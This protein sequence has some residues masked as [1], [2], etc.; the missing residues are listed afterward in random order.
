M[1]YTH[2]TSHLYIRCVIINS[3]YIHNQIYLNGIY[4][5]CFFSKIDIR[6]FHQYYD[7]LIFLIFSNI[8]YLN[9]IFL[10]RCDIKTERELGVFV[11]CIKQNI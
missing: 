6:I 11:I 1:Q 10:Y 4:F 7:I 3:S 9:A 8:Y 2:I 5:C